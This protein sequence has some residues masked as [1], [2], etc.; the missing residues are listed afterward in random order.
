MKRVIIGLFLLLAPYLVA[1]E[2]PRVVTTATTIGIGSSEAYDTYL[3]DM[4][5]TG[6]NI[7][8]NNERMTLAP[9]GNDKL[10]TQGVFNIELDL[11]YNPTLT[12]TT[13]AGYVDYTYSWLYTLRPIDNLK[14]IAGGGIEAM[15][16]FIYNTRNGNNPATAK[17]SVYLTP[18]A[19]AI[20]TLRIKNYPIT[21]RYQCWLPAVGLF[22]SP[23]YQ[24][25][26]YEIFDL[27][28]VDGIV[29]FGAWHNQFSLQQLAT[30]DLPLW[31]NIV[32]LGYRNSMR[33][34]SI[35]SIDSHMYSNSFLIGMVFNKVFVHPL[36]NATRSAFY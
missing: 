7:Q 13:L 14:I 18:S 5:Y 8:F 24:Q 30:V 36:K 3:S 29:H 31:G 28:N 33:S 34:T 1:Q 9:Y 35:N 26:Y 12:G 11:T 22:F 20:Y 2:T 27:G 16:G 21:M 19:A 10:V 6:R 4:L 32:R 23:E 25:S 17:A 15:T